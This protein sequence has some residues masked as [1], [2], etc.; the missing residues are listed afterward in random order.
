MTEEVFP[1]RTALDIAGYDLADMVAGY[2]DYRPED[3]TPGPNHSAGYRW[4]WMNRH[5]DETLEDDGHEYV[6]MAY[7]RMARTAH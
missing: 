1:P 3:P 6:R 4:G 7:I 2:H 5:R